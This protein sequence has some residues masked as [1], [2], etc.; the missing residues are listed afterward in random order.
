MK[1]KSSFVKLIKNIKTIINYT[2]ETVKI[3]MS[4]LLQQF[5][6]PLSTGQNYACCS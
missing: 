2:N 5:N 1:L 4:F 3:E 6:R